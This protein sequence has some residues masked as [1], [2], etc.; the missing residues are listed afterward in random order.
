MRYA[1]RAVPTVGLAL[2]FAVGAASAAE[3]DSKHPTPAPT[4]SSSSSV[5]DDGHGAK[6][7]TDHGTKP[8]EDH[9]TKSGDDHGTKPGTDQEP[10]PGMDMPADEHTEP[11]TRPRG[12]VI[13]GFAAING[14]VLLAAAGVRRRSPAAK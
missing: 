2:M 4:A 5:P 1:A 10:M 13:G 6:P 14:A 9:G 3:A 8:T 7:G 11:V 12:L